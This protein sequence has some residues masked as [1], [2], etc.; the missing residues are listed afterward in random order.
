MLVQAEEEAVT[1]TVLAQV[2]TLAAD[3]LAAGME[4]YCTEG[5]TLQEVQGLLERIRSLLGSIEET[6]DTARD[7]KMISDRLALAQAAAD[8]VYG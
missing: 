5:V 3:S 8:R 6:Y 7:R 1:G 4:G 2:C